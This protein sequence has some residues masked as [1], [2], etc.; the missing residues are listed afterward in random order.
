MEITLETCAEPMLISECDYAPALTIDDLPVEVLKGILEFVPDSYAVL[1]RCVCRLWKELIARRHFNSPVLDW[2]ERG[3]TY[4]AAT[5]LGCSERHLIRCLDAMMRIC[6][7]RRTVSYHEAL[8]TSMY[9]YGYIRT[10]NPHDRSG[11][12]GFVNSSVAI[13]SLLR[14]ASIHGNIALIRYMLRVYSDWIYS[15]KIDYTEVFALSCNPDI[16][17]LFLKRG[18]GLC[19][20]DDCYKQI[21][22]LPEAHIIPMFSCIIKHTYPSIEATEY[23]MHNGLFDVMR[24]SSIVWEEHKSFFF[25]IP[26]IVSDFD[27]I[28]FLGAAK[29][30]PVGAFVMMLNTK[31]NKRK[32]ITDTSH[33]YNR[34]FELLEWDYKNGTYNL[35]SFAYAGTKADFDLL[36]AT[37]SSF[38]CDKKGNHVMHGWTSLDHSILECIMRIYPYNFV[39]DWINVMFLS[40]NCHSQFKHSSIVFLWGYHHGFRELIASDEPHFMTLISDDELNIMQTWLKIEDNIFNNC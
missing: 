27:L 20:A 38:N 35:L 23:L 9:P 6:Y 16:L 34:M 25:A 18:N 24:A 26:E 22:T 39:P 2:L 21:F 30:T 7:T 8:G 32:N 29:I 19:S 13:M 37:V 40:E 4:I 33:L 28:W 17:E 1:M 36:A 14:A 15:N 3:D 12:P 10:R 5:V 31:K 11:A